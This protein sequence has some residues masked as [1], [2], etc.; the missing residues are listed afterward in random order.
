MSNLIIVQ[1]TSNDLAI[2]IVV[3]RAAIISDSD[4]AKD[5]KEGE[6]VELHSWIGRGAS[7]EMTARNVVERCPTSA[8]VFDET[9]NGNT[10]KL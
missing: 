7:P 9:R 5:G 4:G 6:Y 3:V 10:R 8:A 2:A 1:D